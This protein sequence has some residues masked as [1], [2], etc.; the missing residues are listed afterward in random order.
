MGDILHFKQCV[1]IVQKYLLKIPK[2]KVLIT[3]SNYIVGFDLLMHW[4]NI[5]YVAAGKG[6]ANFNFFIYCL[7]A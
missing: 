7:L 1:V 5:T 3:Q 2:V 6:G 4:V